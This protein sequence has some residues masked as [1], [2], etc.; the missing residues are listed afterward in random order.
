MTWSVGAGW[1]LR[2]GARDTFVESSDSDGLNKVKLDFGIVRNERDTL[3]TTAEF[4][5]K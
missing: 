1:G 4:L 5:Q 2:D 3:L